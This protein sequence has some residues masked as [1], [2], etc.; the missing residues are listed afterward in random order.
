M[1]SWKEEVKHVK[2]ALGVVESFME[3]LATKVLNNIKHFR[4][5]VS[6]L[7]EQ[8]REHTHTQGIAHAT[9]HDRL[10]AVETK[11]DNIATQLAAIEKKLDTLNGIDKKLDL[12]LAKL[13]IQGA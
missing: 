9:I 8:F 1:I 4:K 13:G 5:E 2:D 11:V 6:E 10:T 7:S 3:A 12:L